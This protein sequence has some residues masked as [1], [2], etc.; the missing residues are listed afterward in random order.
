MLALESIAG[1]TCVTIAPIRIIGACFLE[2]LRQRIAARKRDVREKEIAAHILDSADEFRRRLVGCDH[3]DRAQLRVLRDF[4]HGCRHLHG[5]ALVAHLDDVFGISAM[6]PQRLDH[7]MKPV[8]AVAV[9]LG[10]NRDLLGANLANIHQ[11]RDDG[12]RFFLVAGAI[13]K[14][15]PIGRTFAQEVGGGESA[16]NGILCSRA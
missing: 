3:H 11:I 10:E 6:T 2:L 1:T 8:L 5:V 9:V 14:H 16:G 4:P 15:V 13:V 12:G 7:A